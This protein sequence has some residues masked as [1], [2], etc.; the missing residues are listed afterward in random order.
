MVPFLILLWNPV[1]KTAWGPA[2]AGLSALAGAFLFNMRM[3]VGAFNAGDVYDVALTRVPPAAW[4]DVWD[5]FMVIGGLGAVIF[6]YLLATK[7]IP[8]LSVWETK[9]GTKYQKMGTLIRGE[10]LVLA[11]PE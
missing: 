11:K 8:I 2:L 6:I 10:Y 3:I 9:E 7:I 5:V 1:R 4:P